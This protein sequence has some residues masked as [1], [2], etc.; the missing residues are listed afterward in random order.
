MGNSEDMIRELF[1]TA[2]ANPPA[3]IFIDELDVL[4]CRSPIDDNYMNHGNKGELLRQIEKSKGDK[5]LLVIAETNAPWRLC[6]AVCRRLAKAIY[7]PMPDTKSRMQ[8]FKLA[9]S[10]TRCFFTDEDYETIGIQTEGYSSTDIIGLAREI[11]MESMKRA[12]SARVFAID[13]EG[14][15]VTTC[16]SNPIGIEQTLL[17]L[18]STHKARC[19]ASMVNSQAKYRILY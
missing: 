10:N 15:Y 18:P 16:P 17:T 5:N 3:I 12:R 8:M 2:R 14:C 7:I 19:V 9:F 13:S 1:E 4:I 6:A 11:A